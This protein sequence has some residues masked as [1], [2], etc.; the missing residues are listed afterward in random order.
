MSWRSKSAMSSSR[1]SLPVTDGCFGFAQ[2][3]FQVEIRQ[4]GGLDLRRRFQDDGALDDVAQF[5]DVARPMVAQQF[6]PRRRRRRRGCACS[7][8]PLKW[9]KKV[10]GQEDDVVA[11]LA[12]GR[13]AKLND[14]EAVEQIFA[15][16]VL[17][18]GFDDVAVG[19]GDEADVHVQFIVAADAGE[20]AVFQKAEQLGLERAAHVA[21]FIQEDGAAVGF[22]DAAE[23]LFDG[24]GEGALF[25]AEKL[26]FEQVL[27][28]GGAVDADVIVLA[29]LAQAVQGAG[30]R[31]P[32]RCR[33]RP[34]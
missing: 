15:E 17:A 11:A 26:A 3:A 18:D 16:I 12:Q 28:N 23:F 8:W 5:A 7:S 29:A 2:A 6:V 20:G 34:G 33:F 25:M 24:A 1:D 13:R 32:C 27:G 30:D 22:F 10:L 21:D 14:I 19:G 9:R 4:A 31:V